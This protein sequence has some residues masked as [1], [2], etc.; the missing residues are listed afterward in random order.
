MDPALYATLPVLFSSAIPD[1]LFFSSPIFMSGASHTR[2]SP[3]AQHPAEMYVAL[4]AHQAAGCRSARPR[5]PSLRRV[6]FRT[7]GI[8]IKAAAAHCK[9]TEVKG[10]KSAGSTVDCVTWHRQ[11]APQKWTPSQS[12]AVQVP[13][14]CFLV[15]TVLKSAVCHRIH[16]RR[17][18]LFPGWLEMPAHGP[19]PNQ[20]FDSSHRPSCLRNP[21]PANHHQ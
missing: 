11:S 5:P 7:R 19:L 8:L 9:T 17:R 15:T 3:L 20:T 6:C 2:P 18:Y 21:N 16:T 14:L 10:P 4:H 1:A 13:E 12:P